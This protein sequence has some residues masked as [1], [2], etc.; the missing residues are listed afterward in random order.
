MPMYEYRCSK[1]GLVFEVRQKFSDPPVSTC[2]ACGAAVE[3]LISLS[4]FALKG[5]GWYDQGYS[6]SSSAA[7]AAPSCAAKSVPSC[8]AAEP[9]CSGCAKSAS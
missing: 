2:N 8:A 3:K 7:K 5:G 4:G 1:C 6:S 9:S